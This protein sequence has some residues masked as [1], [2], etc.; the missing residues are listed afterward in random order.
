M[1]TFKGAIVLEEENQIQIFFL[2]I[3]TIYNINEV[4]V[5]THTFIFEMSE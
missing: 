1:E 3:I 4:I 2:I 5:Q